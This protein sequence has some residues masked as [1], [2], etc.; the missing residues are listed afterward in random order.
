MY[1]RDTDTMYGEAVKIVLRNSSGV[2]SM[3]YVPQFQYNEFCG[4]AAE[5]FQG[6]VEAKEHPFV[7]AVR[8]KR[9]RRVLFLPYGEYNFIVIE[10][11]RS[12][13]LNC[14]FREPIVFNFVQEIVR[15]A[16]AAYN[17]GCGGGAGTTERI[18]LNLCV[19]QF[20][21]FA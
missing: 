3:S 5:F 10:C 6:G 9:G 18:S 13:W 11:D 7:C 8:M 20:L 2:Y 15:M 14:C 12:H 17:P 16:A 19:L 4:A 1:I 21:Y